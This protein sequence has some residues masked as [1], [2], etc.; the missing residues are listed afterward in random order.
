VPVTLN[1]VTLKVTYLT[2]R[3]RL[4]VMWWD[5]GRSEGT[6]RKVHVQLLLLPLLPLP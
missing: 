5:E 3:P 1:V 2:R 6:Y 4:F